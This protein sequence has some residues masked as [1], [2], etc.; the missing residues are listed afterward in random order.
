[1][2]WIKAIYGQAITV[3]ANV[4]VLS[5]LNAIAMVLT[6][7][8][9]KYAFYAHVMNQ[10]LL[11]QL[12]MGFTSFTKKRYMI[13]QDGRRPLGS[14][15]GTTG[16]AV[17]GL[18]FF[19]IST[20]VYQT[21]DTSLRRTADASPAL[22]GATDMPTSSNSQIRYPLISDNYLG[23]VSSN[24]Q[25]QETSLWIQNTAHA[26]QTESQFSGNVSAY[27]NDPNWMSVSDSNGNDFST[28]IYM[29]IDGI[30]ANS[31][32]STTPVTI[33]AQVLDSG[34]P[35]IFEIPLT[36]SGLGTS[37]A[38]A[39]AGKY[40][41]D[42]IHFELATFDA[43]TFSNNDCLD[44]YY[45]FATAHTSDNGTLVLNNT[46]NYS[47]KASYSQENIES[48]LSGGSVDVKY[49][50]VSIQNQTSSNDTYQSYFLSKRAVHRQTTIATQNGTIDVVQ[51]DYNVRIV[52][53]AKSALDSNYRAVYTSGSNKD[54]IN[55]PITSFFR[56]SN[57]DYINVASFVDTKGLYSQFVYETYI[58]I[59]P[60]VILI[61]VYGA[62]T[63]L[64]TLAAYT[65][66]FRRVRNKAFS[67][68]LETLNFVMYTP[69]RVLFPLLQKIR[70]AEFSMVDGFDPSTG[71]N[72]MGLVS[73]EDAE[74]ITRREPDVPYGLVHKT[75]Q[76]ML[77]SQN[78]YA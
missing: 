64:L 63:L 12:R 42:Y 41:L 40:T 48:D 43:E 23:P 4:L 29:S 2:I 47:S 32:A 7:F 62:I 74:H 33:T 46:Y 75:P 13:G 61:A 49:A 56:T 54:G 72:H 34:S 20:I 77:E 8:S 69:G 24:G 70:R 52:R 1:M 22:K 38:V 68:P 58:D 14:F 10:P 30:T 35:A 16:L 27:L 31:L 37:Y 65:Y 71:Y 78:M 76:G 25:L 57:D 73:L 59:L 67:V 50:M 17:I 11:E 51:Y 6:P 39:I 21:S 45:E 60:S 36:S 18:V 53:Y 9:T 66:N 15:L 26:V 55:L 19:F 5:L 3:A 44:R 28:T